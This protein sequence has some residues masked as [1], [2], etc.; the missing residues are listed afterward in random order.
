MG[1]RMAVLLIHGVEINNKD[2]A[3]KASEQLREAFVSHTDGAAL[4]DDLIIRTAFWA[5]VLQANE[6][7][8]MERVGVK[9]LSGYFDRLARLATRADAGS[10][11]AL[12][13]LAASGLLRWL[14]RAR[15]FH[16]PTLRWMA[17][18]YISDAIAYQINSADQELYDQIHAVVA[19]ALGE[20]AQ[21][22]GEDA[23]LCVVAHSLGTVVASNFFYDL[24]AE[25]GRGRP[26]KHLIGKA[27]EAALGSSPLE[28]GETLSF[29]YTLGSPLALWAG[30]L[31]DF[32]EPLTVPDPFAERH[33]PQ[34]AGEWVNIHD[35]D[36]IVAWPLKGLNGAYDDQVREDRA[37]SV[38]RW[39]T[40]WTPL[41]HVGYWNDRKV[42]DPIARA[43]AQAWRT[44]SG[45][46]KDKE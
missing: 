13:S 43:L 44:L 30:R 14:P 42:M 9:S 39:G 33:H 5:P 8:L 21:D 18:H 40:G 20:L 28:R 36:D 7:R 17:I 32:G 25:Y 46:H 1:T 11:L 37:V 10:T 19:K 12:L 15:G 6:D 26:R 41:A 27:T 24:Q 4:Q 16:F 34:I 29:L 45:S 23:P 3:K 31:P 2:F 38:G 35:L 22:A